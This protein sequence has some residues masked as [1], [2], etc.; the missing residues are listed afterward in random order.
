M[1]V[2]IRNGGSTNIFERL[3]KTMYVYPNVESELGGNDFLY[4]IDEFK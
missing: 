4:N 3:R 2:C 1:C